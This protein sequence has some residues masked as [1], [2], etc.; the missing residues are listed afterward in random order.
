M[1]ATQA[2]AGVMTQTP[3]PA[4]VQEP[5]YFNGFYLGVGAGLAKP[6]AKVQYDY[7]IEE[8]ISDDIDDF[9]LLAKSNDSGKYGFGA[10]IFAG[11]GKVFDS[12]TYLGAEIFGNY[13]EPDMTLS[14]STFITSDEETVS[15]SLKTTIENDYSYGILARAG[16]LFSPKTMFYVL[17]GV[18]LSEFD[19]KSA[20]TFDGFDET[21]GHGA[22][23]ELTTVNKFDT[24]KIGYLPGVGMETVIDDQ[25]TL[26]M[27]YVYAFYSSFKHTFNYSNNIEKTYTT[28][29]DPSRGYLSLMLSWYVG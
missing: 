4:P 22:D 24:T 3:M 25:I 19:V 18:E 9:D 7:D 29:V 23:E 16:Y 11:F 2:F 1:T 6:N 13:F 17:F 10:S 26:K 12:T 21:V 14:S 5:E 28:K 20:A 15:A 8:S 27:Q